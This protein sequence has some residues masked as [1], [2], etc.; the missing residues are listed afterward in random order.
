MR[1]LSLALGLLLSFGA[2]AQDY[3]SRTITIIAAGAAGGPTDTVTR[4]VADAM[5]RSIGQSVVVESIGGSV[6]GPQR[7]A[8][9]R[10]DGYTLMINNIGM[11]AS[12]TL[13]R[14]LPYDVPGSF[15]PLG[16]VSDAAMTIIT[17]PDFPARGLGGVMAALKTQGDVLNMAT[18]GLGSAANL[19]ALL[20]QQA[21]GNKATIVVFRGTAPAIAE[22]MAGR[23]DLLC[24]QA[25]NTIPYIRENRVTPWGVS[26]PA[27]LPGLPNVPTTAEA[28]F[29][30][31]AMS[32]WH[33]LYAPAGTPEDVQQKVNAALQK[34][35]QD[36]RLRA[37]YAEL[38]T[39]VPSAERQQIG[40]HRRFLAE[41]VARWR[42]IIQAAGAYAD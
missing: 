11:A 12:A 1:A 29:G 22:L 3:P 28:G 18:A 17:R 5:T 13:F 20:V 39:D 30:S 14:K 23:I 2:A 41:E 32:T 36:E 31:I 15:A 16:L 34:A 7:L 4:I 37:R 35:L 8:Q 24:D 26:S 27:R 19:C 10:P 42:P 25:T 38:L 21:A 9:S 6:V 33:G 40:F